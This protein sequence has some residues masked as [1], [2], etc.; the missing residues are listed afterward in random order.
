MS[1]AAP[2]WM[3]YPR[4]ETRSSPHFHAVRGPVREAYRRLDFAKSVNTPSFESGA[5][6]DKPT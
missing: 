5:L 6:S 4:K 1:I 3:A 2:G